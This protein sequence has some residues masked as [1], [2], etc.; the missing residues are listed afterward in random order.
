MPLILVNRHIAA[1]SP[2]QDARVF[3]ALSSQSGPWRGVEPEK[4]FRAVDG[5]SP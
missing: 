3:P 5:K 2:S 4:W 1:I